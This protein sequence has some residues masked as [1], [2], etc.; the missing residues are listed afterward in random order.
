MERVSID[1]RAISPHV[2]EDEHMT[3][4]HILHILG[5]RWDPVKDAFSYQVNLGPKVVTNCEM[6]SVIICIHDPIGLLAPVTFYAKMIMQRLWKSIE[7]T[8]SMYLSISSET[9]ISFRIF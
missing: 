4:V 5:I 6:L 7:I 1:D 3:C 9:I 8:Q 2:F